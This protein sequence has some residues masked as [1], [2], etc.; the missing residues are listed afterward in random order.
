[1]APTS[2]GGARVRNKTKDAAKGANGIADH[3]GDLGFNRNVTGDRQGLPARVDN[4][5]GYLR[6]EG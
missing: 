1:M 4:F 3:C 2:L 5:I 6:C